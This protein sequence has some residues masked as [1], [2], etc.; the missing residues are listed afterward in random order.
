[1]PTAY[2]TTSAK[3][4]FVN[5]SNGLI[6]GVIIDHP[7]K[8]FDI[9]SAILSQISGIY[10][11]H[12]VRL[13]V[14]PD[15]SMTQIAKAAGSQVVGSLAWLVRNKLTHLPMVSGGTP[16][17]MND[18][19]NVNYVPEGSKAKLTVRISAGLLAS[20]KAGTVATGS[21]NNTIGELASASDCGVSNIKVVGFS[22][23]NNI[24]YNPATGLI[25]DYPL[26]IIEV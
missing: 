4:M 13:T 2:T 6:Q 20:L 16:A 10:G 7:T 11:G 25:E 3:N 24:S 12:P 14:N 8:V 1:M 26:A 15:G 5:S 22:D 21:W 17:L 19:D 9:S 18:G 23:K